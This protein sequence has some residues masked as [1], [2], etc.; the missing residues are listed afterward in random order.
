[1]RSQ[2]TSDGVPRILMISRR[3]RSSVVRGRLFLTAKIQK[4]HSSAVVT[5]SVLGSFQSLRSPI[6]PKHRV[7]EDYIVS[8]AEGTR[9]LNFLLLST[10]APLRNT[11]SPATSSNELL[12]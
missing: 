3:F 6:C 5:A 4:Y 8:F 1:M 2:G 12:R 11:E 9:L 10:R 7:A